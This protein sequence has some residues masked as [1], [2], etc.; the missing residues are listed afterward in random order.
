V[1]RKSFLIGTLLGPILMGVMIFAP[2]LILQ[3]SPASQMN[4]AVVDFQGS[5]FEKMQ[6]SLTDTLKSGELMFNLREIKATPDQVG[7]VK[8]TLNPEVE[9]DILDAYIILPAEIIENNQAVLY[10]KRVGDLKAFERFNSAVN[11]AVIGLRLASEGFDHE[12]VGKLVKRVQIES[13]MIKEGGKEE[14][15]QFELMFMSTFIFVMMLYM[16]ILMWGVAVMRSIIEEKNNR[17]VEVLLSSLRPIDLLFGKIFGVGAVGLTQYAIWAA[18]SVIMV[19]YGLSMG[20]MMAEVVAHFSLVTLIYF[21]IYYLLGFHFYSTLF[22]GVGSICNS[23]QEAQQLQTPIVLCLVFTIMIPML[24]I[25]NPDSTFATI[26][27]LIPFFTPIVMFM[28]ITILM[29]PV[30]QIA[31]S[32]LIM[33]VSIYLAGRVAAKI[34][35]VGILMYGKRPDIREVLKWLKR[36]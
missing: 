30:W 17:V 32:I 5:L 13:M 21:I 6:A 34:F 12:V 31:L 18:V 9:S 14:K 2:A 24:I 33:L 28:R 22:A 7:K 1:R 4:I 10:G 29:P 19:L 27:S 3:L 16:T 36:A 11:N 23:D 8:K 25:Q 20:G 35:Q 26:V 15:G